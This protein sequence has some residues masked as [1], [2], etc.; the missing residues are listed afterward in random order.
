MKAILDSYG[1]PYDEILER[2]PDAVAYIDDK[3]I[4]FENWTGISA[5]L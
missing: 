4:R 3:A 1:V 5:Y 2:K